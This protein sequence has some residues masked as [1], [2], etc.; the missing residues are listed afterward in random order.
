MMKEINVYSG[1]HYQVE[2]EGLLA[3]PL[4]KFDPEGRFRPLP[5]SV[6]DQQTR[7]V[8]EDL[9]HTITEEQ[10]HMTDDGMRAVGIYQFISDLDPDHSNT[11]SFYNANDKSSSTKMAAGKIQ[12]ICLNAVITGEVVY[13]T[14][15]TKFIEDRL[16][17]LLS[18]AVTKI[19][20]YIKHQ[21]I[22]HIAYKRITLDQEETK[23]THQMK[24]D[25]L[26][27]EATRNKVIA[28]SAIGAVEHQYWMPRHEEFTENGYSLHRFLQAF[29]QVF[30]DRRYSYRRLTKASL[31]LQRIFNRQFKTELEQVGSDIEGTLQE[32]EGW[33]LNE[34]Q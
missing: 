16:P 13:K 15:H 22:Q 34:G 6:M 8:V 14:C 12:H 25:H 18:E 17:V 21:E 24:V 2:L 23:K 33:R 5:H 30:Q 28:G 1:S 27:M 32:M 3:A 19:G 9:G 11:V 7:S 10:F 4:P 26:I 31:E 29:T 20:G